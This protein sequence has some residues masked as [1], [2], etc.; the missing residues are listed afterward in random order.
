MAGAKRNVGF[1]MK[2]MRVLV[3]GATGF[4]GGRLVESLLQDSRWDVRAM[5]HRPGRA[6]RLAR[7]KVELVWADLLHPYSIRKALEGVDAIVHCAYGANADSERA[8]TVDGTRNLVEQ[9]R[10][11]GVRKFVHISTISVHSF[12]PPPRVSEDSPCVR[13]GDAYCDA[14]I[15]AETIVRRGYPE[16]VVLR[17]GNIYGPFSSPWTLRPLMHIKADMV[18]LVEGGKNPANV[19][20]VD[21]AIE[22]ITLAISQDESNGQVYFV[23]DDP[24]S[25]NEFYGH[26]ARWLDGKELVSAT[27][28]D[29]RLWVK[30]TKGERF[31]AFNR[32]IW[33]GVILPT[34][35][36]A[37]FRVAVSPV[38]G[39]AA[40]R[41]WQ[42]VPQAI[43][44]RIVGDP[45]GRSVPA[46]T[47]SLKLNSAEY[48][49]PGLLQIY[50][51]R[52]VFGNAKIKN[53]LGYGPKISFAEAMERTRLWADWA[54]LLE[55]GK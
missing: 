7:Q 30:P 8:V 6:V 32:E 29:I 35:R 45:L 52:T 26:Y 43:R 1:A 41:L 15:E 24:V 54:R 2:A 12:T 28:E 50:A 49:S 10:R 20:Y 46:A 17:M 18:S 27:L 31:T 16:A 33:G 14:K 3:T 53:M 4:L 40:S 51:G 19:V 39:A 34:V 11:A 47:A 37:A 55:C 44:Y 22:A 36:Y 5:A 42:K 25:W 23:T 9:A 38:L 48:P 21:N 13:S